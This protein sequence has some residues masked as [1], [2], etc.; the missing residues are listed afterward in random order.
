MRR[1]DARPGR[2]RPTAGRRQTSH[3][4]ITQR[5]TPCRH[6][7]G[8]ARVVP[9]MKASPA[10]PQPKNCW[11]PTNRP[12]RPRHRP[13]EMT[14]ETSSRTP[15]SSLSSGSSQQKNLCEYFQ[16]HNSKTFSVISSSIIRNGLLKIRPNSMRVWVEL[17]HVNFFL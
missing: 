6:C 17:R 1:C 9:P 8:A 3:S 12:S 16:V 7:F 10:H 15:V 14:D 5:I 13:V 4:L 11:G 2:T